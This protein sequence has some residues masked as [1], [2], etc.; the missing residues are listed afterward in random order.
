M[1]SIVLVKQVPDVAN[2]PPDAWDRTKGTLK[3]SAL[4]NVLNPLDL[5]ALTF[6]ARLGGRGSKVICLTM[7]PP[8]AREILLNCLARRADEAV[9][10]SDPA[11]AG[12]D[13]CATAY[14][15]AQAIR[16]IHA[17][18]LDGSDYLIVAG[19]QSADGDTAQ[20]PPQ[21]AEELGI[22]HIAYAESFQ[23]GHELLIRRI[24]PGG[25]EQVSPTA[26]PVLITVTGC[27]EPFYRSFA[28]ARA[29]LRQ[30]I[31]EWKADT[32]KA[33]GTRIGLKGSRT[34]VLR[35]FAPTEAR[36][37]ECL[38]TG[39]LDALLDQL[40][41]RYGN[42]VY[43]SLRRNSTPYELD[44]KTPSYR[45]EVWV[46]IEH[47]EGKINPVSLQLLGTARQLAERLAEK[48]GGVVLGDHVAPLVRQIIQ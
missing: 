21:I 2:I 37:R 43:E 32:I 44:G 4:E 11:F 35:I 31:H 47:E 33:D 48:V 16:K 10:L 25:V 1:N 38:K 29:A 13:T 41:Q 42:G 14:A 9:L 20:V 22:E 5:H 7:G 8:Q 18:R 40:S 45:G 24:G 19:M 30:Q 28:R 15:L 39:D 6:A 36:V 34:Q 46:F 17:E 27:T 12:A 3:R 26:Y 23:S